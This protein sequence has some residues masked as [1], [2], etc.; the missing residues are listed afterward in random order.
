MYVQVRLVDP[1]AE[2]GRVMVATLPWQHV[3]DFCD[4]LWIIIDPIHFFPKNIGKLLTYLGEISL[5]KTGECFL[6]NNATPKKS[7][8]LVCGEHKGYFVSN[9]KTHIM[10]LIP[11]FTYWS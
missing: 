7:A 4:L 6:G 10:I 8:F 2:K 9:G 5:L 11:Y 3:F 1:N